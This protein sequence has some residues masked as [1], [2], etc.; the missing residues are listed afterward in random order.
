[1]DKIGQK[2]AEAPEY[3]ESSALLDSRGVPIGGGGGYLTKPQKLA[4]SPFPELAVSELPPKLPPGVSTQA[5]RTGDSRRILPQPSRRSRISVHTRQ[6]KSLGEFH[7]H[8]ATGADEL[9]RAATLAEYLHLLRE[10]DQ[11]GSASGDRPLPKP[12][13]R[14]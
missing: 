7:R 11:V 3:S 2:K 13:L 9:G 4:L 8:A 6:H 12:K 10:V 5:A 14:V 1:L